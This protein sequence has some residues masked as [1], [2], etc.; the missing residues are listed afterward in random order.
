MKNFSLKT[1]LIIFM[2]SSCAPYD[3]S[4]NNSY[5]PKGRYYD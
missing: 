2:L 5:K 1:I 3:Y 4:N